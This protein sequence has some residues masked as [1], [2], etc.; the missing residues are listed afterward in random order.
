M[1]PRLPRA[2]QSLKGAEAALIMAHQID[3]I[4]RAP[5][6]CQAGSQM[7]RPNL[8]AAMRVLLWPDAAQT[9]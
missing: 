2:A 7:E 6:S 4:C 1:S 9:T 8:T 5:R 3:L